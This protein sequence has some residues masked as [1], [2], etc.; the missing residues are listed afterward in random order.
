MDLLLKNILLPTGRRC[1]L[2]IRG[3]V[4]AHIGGPARADQTIDCGG[5]LCLPG[6]ID[7]H[8][9]MRDGTQAYKETWKT[10]SQSALA[11]GITLVVDQPNCI[12]PITNESILKERISAARK[13]SFCHFAINAAVTPGAA[14]EEMW[15]SGAMAF[16]E[17]FMTESS[18]AEGIPEQTL[19]TALK[20]I[21]ALGA[22]ATIHAEHILAGADDSLTAHTMIRPEAGEAQAVHR[23]EDLAPS[24]IALHFCHLSCGMAI[25]AAIGTVEV[26]PHHLFLSLERFH[27][28][29]GEG[30][31]NPPLR[32][33]KTR[34]QLWERWN[35]I[36]VVASDHAPHTR[37]EKVRDFAEVPPGIPGVET[38]VPL[39]L[40]EVQKSRISLQSVMEK[41]MFN[42]AAIMGLPKREIHPGNPADLALYPHQARFISADQL[43]SRA[44]WSPFE[45]ME[46]IFPEIVLVNG[47]VALRNDEFYETPAQWVPGSGYIPSQIQ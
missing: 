35:R 12:P 26:T 10:G 31:V 32:R 1:D 39:L 8:V 14:L 17:I 37:D 4:I 5:M 3:G 9:H 28:K 30:K 13:A 46:A 33:E 29:D 19:Q 41:T 7:M 18:F 15:S 43:H 22:T 34:K 27:P 16:G 42:P 23:I 45:G 38:M 40:A 2:S 25:D 36:N 44:G 24:R 20:R 21:Q 47:V 11:G 6:A